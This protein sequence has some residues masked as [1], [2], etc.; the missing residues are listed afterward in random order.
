MDY[1][2]QTQWIG[3][4][5]SMQPTPP[6]APKRK[7][8]MQRGNILRLLTA[9]PW[10]TAV[11]IASTLDAKP[12]DDA[13]VKTAERTMRRMYQARIVDRSRSEAGQFIFGVW[14]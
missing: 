14:A 2:P 11:E 8:Q 3:D 7:R 10:L 5:H 1:I 9:K 13:Q 12:A 6:A 4:S